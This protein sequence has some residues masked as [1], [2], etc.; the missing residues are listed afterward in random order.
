MEDGLDLLSDFA[1]QQFQYSVAGRTDQKMVYV[2]REDV[3]RDELDLL[4]WFQGEFSDS[5]DHAQNLGYHD[6]TMNT[7]PK[8]HL[9]A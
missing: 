8:L 6:T 3:F 4:A 7:L 1:I 5:P 9:G 2:A